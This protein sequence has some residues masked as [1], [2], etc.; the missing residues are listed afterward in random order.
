[1]PG[2]AWKCHNEGCGNDEIVQISAVDLKS[3]IF[4]NFDTGHVNIPYLSEESE[5]V[6]RNR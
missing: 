3:D 2:F 4:K 5:N 6:N 1:M